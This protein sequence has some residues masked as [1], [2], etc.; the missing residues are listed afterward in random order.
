MLPV[1]I[2]GSGWGSD[3][4]ALDAAP[5]PQDLPAG[6]IFRLSQCRMEILPPPAPFVDVWKD[7]VHRILLQVLDSEEAALD[8]APDPGHLPAVM[9]LSCL[10][11]S[12]IRWS[13]CCTCALNCTTSDLKPVFAPPPASPS[14]APFIAATIAFASDESCTKKKA[15]GVIVCTTA[16]AEDLADLSACSRRSSVQFFRVRRASS[17]PNSWSSAPGIFNLP[18]V[19]CRLFQFWLFQRR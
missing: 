12:R 4:A 10:S 5:D 14:R 7:G 2:A 15:T 11:K 13:C 16:R 17:T 3:D 1:P 9:S 19:L 6:N 18:R 8:A